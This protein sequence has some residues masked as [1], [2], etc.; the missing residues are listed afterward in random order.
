VKPVC[1]CCLLWDFLV[2]LQHT[3]SFTPSFDRGTAEFL[4]LST[5]AGLFFIPTSNE[6]RRACQMIEMTILSTIHHPGKANSHRRRERPVPERKLSLR[7]MKRG[8]A[9]VRGGARNPRG[10]N[11]TFNQFGVIR[12]PYC[13]TDNQL[14]VIEDTKTLFAIRGRTSCDSASSSNI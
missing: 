10:Q 3:G 7:R 14:K 6:H 9:C 11:R 4:S 8:R 1:T 5:L 12:R 13:G 2:P